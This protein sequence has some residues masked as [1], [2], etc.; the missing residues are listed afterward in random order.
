MNLSV[1]SFYYSG[2]M[3]NITYGTG[4]NL[5]T[6]KSAIQRNFLDNKVTVLYLASS[7]KQESYM[8]AVQLFF[9]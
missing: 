9:L 4:F 8:V 6:L 5:D 3:L 2:A 1:K 7:L